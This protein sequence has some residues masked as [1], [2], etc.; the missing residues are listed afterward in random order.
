V[1]VTN[2]DG[3]SGTLFGG[4]VV[5]AAPPQPSTILPAQGTNDI[6]NNVTIDGF[7]FQPGVTVSLVQGSLSFGFVDVQRVNATQVQAVVP[8]SLPPGRY[9]VVVANPGTLTTGVISAGYTVLAA[10]E[11]TIYV[12]NADIWTD[13]TTIRQGETV[14]LGL[15]LHRIG[16]KTTVQVPVSFYQGDPQNGG[17]LLGSTTSVPIP[18]NTPLETVFISWT[19]PNTPGPVTI[20]ALVDPNDTLGTSTQ[21]N[22]KAVWTLTVLGAA[23]DTTPPE[24]TNLVLDGGVADTSNPVLNVAITADDPAGGS[25]LA[26]MYLVERVFSDAAQSWIPIQTTG[27]IPFQA[28]TQFTL[29]RSAGIR[30]IQAYVADAAGN[31]SLNVVKAQINYV[32]PSDSLLQNQVQVYR[33]ELKAGDTLAVSVQPLSGDADLYVWD[34]NS[35]SVLVSNNS[36]TAVDQGSIVASQSGAYQIEVYAYTDTTYSISISI[37]GQPAVQHANARRSSV[38][39]PN[40]LKPLRTSPVIPVSDEPEGKSAIPAAPVLSTPLPTVTST[41][42]RASHRV[43]L[44]LV[45]DSS[46]GGW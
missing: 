43:Y 45:T 36:G 44:P 35:N 34:P 26:T 18:P 39:Q 23:P 10:G 46:A 7:N 38:G 29:T 40:A 25:G 24:I 5:T 21:V 6:P 33:E 1:V 16:G 15:N 17:T 11:D 42:T 30:Y 14:Q 41:P 22:N 32:L 9:D 4:F 19:V 37:N 31:I 28:N 27:W 12:N 3:T 2:A 13:P 8:A 20:T